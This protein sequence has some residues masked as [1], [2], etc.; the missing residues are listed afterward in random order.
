M[1]D[2]LKEAERAGISQEDGVDEDV[3]L[4]DETMETAECAAAT[5]ETEPEYEPQVCIDM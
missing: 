3:V 2:V 5:L 1:D 4:K